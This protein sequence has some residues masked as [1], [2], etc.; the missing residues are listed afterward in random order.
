MVKC[1]V[2]Q[3]LVAAATKIRVQRKLPNFVFVNK[4]VTY[5]TTHRI[6]VSFSVHLTS[7]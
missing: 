3:M 1:S 7:S 6:V 2:F 5:E 4:D